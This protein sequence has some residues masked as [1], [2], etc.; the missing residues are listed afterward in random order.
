MY[1]PIFSNK[2]WNFGESCFSEQKRSEEQRRS[3]REG[4]QS[5]RAGEQR[6]VRSE[7]RGEKVVVA[8]EGVH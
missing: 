3:V 6:R 1:R 7:S 2:F 4:V 8:G 5:R